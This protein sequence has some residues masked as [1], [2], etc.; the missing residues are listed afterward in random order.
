MLLEVHTYRQEDVRGIVVYPP[1]QHASI[2]YIKTSPQII[3][4]DND[5]ASI[6]QNVSPNENF[7][8]AFELSS[9][10]AWGVRFRG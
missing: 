8:E 9:S 3:I 1:K 5:T 4:S 10:G 6:D 7:D 2:E